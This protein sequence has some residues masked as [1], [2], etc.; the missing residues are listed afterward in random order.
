[1]E[2]ARWET[3]S[4]TP[5]R[6][7]VS[8]RRKDQDLLYIYLCPKDVSL[9]PISQEI[10][11]E[12]T[13]NPDPAQSSAPWRK[14]PTSS[15]GGR[16]EWQGCRGFRQLEQAACTCFSAAFHSGHSPLPPGTSTSAAAGAQQREKQLE[17][18]WRARPSPLGDKWRAPLR[19]SDSETAMA[20][21]PAVT[22]STSMGGL[23]VEAENTKAL[24]FP[25]FLFLFS[26]FFCPPFGS[27]AQQG[28]L[29]TCVSHQWL[30]Q[31]LW[32]TGENTRRG[33]N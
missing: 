32:G 27:I 16:C 3:E 2:T 1:M 22:H 21:R 10:K 9:V 19:G 26:F 7:N 15:Q 28:C 30:P 8:R 29:E 14:P 25:S 11:V 6:H 24:F 31:P 4:C 18:H 13:E 23:S 12:N 5:R 17:A 20:W 33:G